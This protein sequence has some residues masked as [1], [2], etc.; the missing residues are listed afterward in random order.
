M[1]APVNASLAPSEGLSSQSFRDGMARLAAAVTVVTS[2]GPAGRVGFTATAVTSVTDE[3]PTVLVCVN[4]NSS[5]FAAVMKN[6][7]LAVNVLTAEQQPIAERFG[8]KVAMAERFD[9]GDWHRGETGAPLLR[10]AAATFDCRV[11]EGVDL[12]T[13]R[14]L[15][16]AV[17]AIVMEPVPSGLVYFSRRYR[18]LPA[19]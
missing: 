10:Q 13:H 7:V 3:P 14:V 1:N 18:A 9:A 16:C 19:G 6:G 17:K 2:D 5:S 15:Y 8:G 11:V 4:R 12:G